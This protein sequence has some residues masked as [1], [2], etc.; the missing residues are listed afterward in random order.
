MTDTIEYIGSTRTDAMGRDGRLVLSMCIHALPGVDGPTAVGR[1][2]AYYAIDLAIRALEHSYDHLSNVGQENAERALAVLREAAPVADD[3]TEYYAIVG[4]GKGGPTELLLVTRQGN[5]LVAES[6]VA[7]YASWDEAA[8]AMMEANG[9]PPM[10]PSE[11]WA[12]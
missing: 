4:A 2:L 9:F 3:I 5:T 6:H 11:Q 10:D 12:G 1:Q 8:R 7:T